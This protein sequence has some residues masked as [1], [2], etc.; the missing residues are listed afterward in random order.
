MCQFV[1]VWE[2]VFV[3]VTSANYVN[4]PQTLERKWSQPT[5]IYAELYNDK[6]KQRFLTAKHVSA[7]SK[8]ITT[9]QPIIHFTR[10]SQASTR[11]NMHSFLLGMLLHNRPA[12]IQM[13]NRCTRY[14]NLDVCYHI[15]SK[16]SWT[17][18]VELQKQRCLCKWWLVV[19]LIMSSGS[20]LL[21]VFDLMVVVGLFWLRCIFI[22]IEFIDSI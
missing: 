22:L 14:G 6:L 10:P 2:S 7:M 13:N 19:S 9:W 1:C 11:H 8:R 18:V 5:C 17:V 12:S 4:A 20:A 3:W 15:L 21:L 16:D